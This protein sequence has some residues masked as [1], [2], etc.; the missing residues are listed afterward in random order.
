MKGIVLIS[1]GAMARGMAESATFFLGDNIPQLACCCLRQDES[2]EDFKEEI[3]KAMT[4][5]D[6]GEGVI[7]LADLFGGTPCN[8]AMGLL[9][10]QVELIAGVNFPMLL[11]LLTTRM[12]G[13]IDISE[14]VQKSQMSVVNAKEILAA[15]MVDD[16]D[17]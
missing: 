8:Q 1:H 17:E 15:T 13:D 14:L 9:G 2:P 11:E 7:L 4:Q 5:V 16:E 12:C 6:T 10:D 3:Q